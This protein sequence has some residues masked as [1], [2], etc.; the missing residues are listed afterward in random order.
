MNTGKGAKGGREKKGANQSS[1]RKTRQRRNQ[2]ATATTIA[3]TFNNAAISKQ[4]P[5]CIKVARRKVPLLLH[6]YS[7]GE[8]FVVAHQ[9]YEIRKRVDMSNDCPIV[10]R[11]KTC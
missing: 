8:F 2:T 4:G 10:G 11:L 5:V 6:L 9:G 7:K 1:K 3:A